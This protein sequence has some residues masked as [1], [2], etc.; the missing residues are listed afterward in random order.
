M[1]RF[2]IGPLSRGM[3]VGVFGGSFDPPH[4][5]HVQL[6]REALTRFGLDRVLWMV[7]PGNPLKSNPP[8][9]LDQRIA[10]CRALITHPRIRVSGAEAQMQTRYTAQTLAGLRAGFPGVRFVW[11]MGADNL[12]QFHLWNDWRSIMDSVPVGVLARPGHRLSARRSVAA[13]VYRSARLAASQSHLLARHKA[14]CWC[15]CNMPLRPESSTALRV[16][17]QGLPGANR[18][19]G[20]APE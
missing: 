13:Q 19:P 16:E 7:S 5:G 1:N 20:H 15:F 4:G 10:A 2:D 14:P 3:A 8:A 18:L 6:S 9:P 11:L 17:G 12:A